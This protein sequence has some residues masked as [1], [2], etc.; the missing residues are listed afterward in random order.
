MV[1]VDWELIDGSF[2]IHIIFRKE[3]T[4]TNAGIYRREELKL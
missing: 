2:P 4:A 3:E 1:A